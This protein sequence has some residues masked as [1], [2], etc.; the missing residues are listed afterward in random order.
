MD[1][2]KTQDNYTNNLS[3]IKILS[4]ITTTKDFELAV[5]TKIDHTSLFRSILSRL[6]RK[7]RQSDS[8]LTFNSI[9]NL[10]SRGQFNSILNNNNA[11]F[12]DVKKR[13]DNEIKNKKIILLNEKSNE[14]KSVTVSYSQTILT[15]AT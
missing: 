14:Y 7:T 12:L 5:I 2:G 15:I 8:F 11:I 10:V 6:E 13:K 4:S 3:C 9:Y 1:N